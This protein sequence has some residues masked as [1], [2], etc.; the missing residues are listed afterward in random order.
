MT[1]TKSN[2]MKKLAVGAAMTLALGG[3]AVAVLQPT[4]ASAAVASQGADDPVGH[5][6]HGADDLVGHVASS[7][8]VATPRVS[9]PR[10]GADDPAGHVRHGADDVVGHARHGADD[11]AGD[12]RHDADGPIGHS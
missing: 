9:L 7:A 5:V 1:M 12:V 6:R 11:K 3:G 8:S 4:L 10:H 2:R